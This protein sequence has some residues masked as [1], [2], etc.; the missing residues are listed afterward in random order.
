MAPSSRQKITQ[1]IDDIA[2]VCV[3]GPRWIIV[4]HFRDL[5][6]ICI[7]V[8]SILTPKIISHMKLYMIM[9][10]RARL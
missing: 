8:D 5:A 4:L 9:C 1:N 2:G 3:I 7:L 10:N 6:L